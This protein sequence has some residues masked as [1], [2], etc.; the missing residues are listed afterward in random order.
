MADP[1]PATV[2]V[3]HIGLSVRNL[4][5]TRRFFCDCLGWNIIGERPEYPAVFVSDGSQMV[6]LWQV[7]SPECA[8]AF[9]RRAN[10]GLHHLA[11]AVADRPGL[12]AL[13]ERVASWPTLSWNSLRRSP[14]KDRRSISWYGNRAAFGLN[15]PTIPASKWPASGSDK[16]CH[17]RFQDSR[18]SRR[19]RRGFLTTLDIRPTTCQQRVWRLALR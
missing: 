17:A 1:T 19:Q 12:D 9:D 13:H 11:L 2:G 3:D 8:V 14:G 7:E 16:T 15:S 10:I 4:E 6:T 5:S 18:S